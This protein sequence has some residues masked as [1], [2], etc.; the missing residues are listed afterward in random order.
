ML[1][2][3]IAFTS[4]IDGD[5]YMGQGTTAARTVHDSKRNKRT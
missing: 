5:A 3:W 2:F 1:Q 4:W